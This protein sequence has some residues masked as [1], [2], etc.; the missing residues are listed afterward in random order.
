MYSIIKDIKTFRNKHSKTLSAIESEN[1]VQYPN[2][3]FIGASIELDVLNSNSHT[4]L[5]SVNTFWDIGNSSI[6]WASVYESSEDDPDNDAC[7]D[8]YSDIEIGEIN[9]VS[10]HL[11]EIYTKLKE[12]HEEY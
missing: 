4:K 1:L 11:F 8:E 10:P 3:K 7:L 9:N 2:A 5:F 12:I 6:L